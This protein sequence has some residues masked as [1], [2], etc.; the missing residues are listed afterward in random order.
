M[1][2]VFDKYFGKATKVPNAMFNQHLSKAISCTMQWVKVH[3]YTSVRTHSQDEKCGL[4]TS[5][6]Q[7]N[8]HLYLDQQLWFS[9]CCFNK[10]LKNYL[11]QIY[12]IWSSFFPGLGQ[13]FWLTA[14]PGSRVAIQFLFLQGKPQIK[15]RNMYVTN[16]QTNICGPV[17]PPLEQLLYWFEFNTAP[18]SMFKLGNPRCLCTFIYRNNG[19]HNLQRVS[20]NVVA[21]VEMRSSFET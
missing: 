18:S 13:N 3:W 12:N 21:R 11:D 6:Q 8:Q 1:L 2:P 20:K 14:L 10:D 5:L 19:S 4:Q 9:L 17:P 15:I 7:L 16:K